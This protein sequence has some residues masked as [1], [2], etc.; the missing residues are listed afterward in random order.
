MSDNTT[1]I[2]TV[3]KKKGK[4]L[5]VLAA[6]DGQ[7]LCKF[8]PIFEH[9]HDFMVNVRY[10]NQVILISMSISCYPCNSI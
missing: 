6:K 3:Q 2:K 9:Q 7:N 10:Q 5:K 4:E 8:L 1:D